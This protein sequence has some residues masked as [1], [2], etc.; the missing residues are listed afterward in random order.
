MVREKEKNNLKVNNVKLKNLKVKT[1]FKL[2]SFRKKDIPKLN[3][4]VIHSQVGYADGVS[5][6]MNQV[7]SVMA[8]NMQIPKSNVFYL[9]GK[10]KSSS[11][12]IRQK[13]IL[14]HKNSTNKLLNEH[15]NKGFGGALSERIEMAIWEAKEEIKKFICDKKIDV[16]I[17][18]NT[19]H[20]VN[21]VLSVA[22]SRYYRDE[23]M[24]KRRPPKYILWWHDSHLERDRY[25]H[26]SLDIK[27]YLLEGVPGK[28]VEYIIF[29]N[30]LQF[31]MAEKYLLELDGRSPGFYANLI[32]NHAV[33]YNT[34]TNVLNSVEDLEN[35]KFTDRAEKFLEEFKIN[36]L[37]K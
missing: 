34:A 2:R 33:V 10:A 31:D 30:R 26:P 9:V 1:Q 4:G 5:I 17:A 24:A 11:P 22:L 15:F 18:H 12:Y 20:P 36:E 3:Y 16:I 8:E 35:E 19:S 29:I 27:N 14:W 25:K 6:V 28:Y 7:E 21:F 23:I 32:K 13:N 37:L